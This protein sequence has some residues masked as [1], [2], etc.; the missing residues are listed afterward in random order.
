MSRSVIECLIELHTLG[1]TEDFL[2][3]VSFISNPVAEGVETLVLWI[4][5]G[6]FFSL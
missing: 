4:N 6:S 1:G 3:A 5:I 2:D